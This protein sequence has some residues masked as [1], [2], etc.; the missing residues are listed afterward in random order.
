MDSGEAV[1]Q[2]V[3][4]F[5]DCAFGQRST[6]CQDFGQARAFDI[7]RRE[8]CGPVRGEDLLGPGDVGMA[9]LAEGLRLQ[10]ET[11]EAPA[12]N[13]ALGFAAAGGP[14]DRCRGAPRSSAA[15][16]P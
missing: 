1:E 8:I 6:A 5:A 2:R 3:E 14:C 4:D 7:V 12:V 15:G 11:I 13:F 16:I 9:D 10:A